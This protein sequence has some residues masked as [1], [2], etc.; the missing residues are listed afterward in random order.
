MIGC[1]RILIKKQWLKSESREAIRGFLSGIYNLVG[2]NKKR[3]IGNGNQIDKQNAILLKTNIDIVGSNN[4]IV[5]A[6]NCQ[7]SNLNIRVRGHHHKVSIGEGCTILKGVIWVEDDHCVFEIG[8]KTT[9]VEAEFGITEPGLRVVI[10]EDCMFAHGKEIRCGDSHSIIDLKNGERI[11]Y[12]KNVTIGKHV[13]IASDVMILKG[14]SIGDDC[15]IAARSLVTRSF[16]SNTL[17]AGS[18]ATTLRQDISWGR[19]RVGKKS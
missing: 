9:I 16:P 11:N 2:K 18:P 17:L 10:G 3:V 13:W 19:D 1:I 12:A 15:V 14:V 7:I 8:A 4:Q 5:I 6:K